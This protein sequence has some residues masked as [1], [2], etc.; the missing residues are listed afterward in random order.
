MSNVTPVGNPTRLTAD[1]GLRTLYT[2][3]NILLPRN[4]VVTGSLIDPSFCIGNTFNA[5]V[6]LTSGSG[7]SLG[8]SGSIIFIDWSADKVTYFGGGSTGLTGS[9]ITGSLA[10]MGSWN[11]F[12][13]TGSFPIFRVLMLNRTG[14]SISGSIVVTGR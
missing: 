3:G 9:G 12:Q 7:T 6:L 11:M 8:D 4:I 14:S 2:S 1:M 13:F 5:F 10:L